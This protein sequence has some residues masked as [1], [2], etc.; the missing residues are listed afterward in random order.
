MRWNE[1]LKEVE[2]LP[3]HMSTSRPVLGSDFISKGSYFYDRPNSLPLVI[4]P[5]LL[6]NLN[7]CGLF[8]GTI[9]E[10]GRNRPEKRKLVLY[11]GQCF[12]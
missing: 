8:G 4:E 1:P 11:V 2:A 9:G 5:D 3:R 10:F 12:F 7:M 6:I